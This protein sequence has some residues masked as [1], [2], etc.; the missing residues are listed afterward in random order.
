MNRQSFAQIGAI[1]RPKSTK[2]EFIRAVAGRSPN[3]SRSTAQIRPTKDK[4]QSDRRSFAP[5]EPIDRPERNQT[6]S[7]GRSF[8]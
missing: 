1:D 6:K 2:F 4:K 7:T 5:N 8:A 3:T